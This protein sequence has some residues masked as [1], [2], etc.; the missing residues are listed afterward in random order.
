MLQDDGLPRLVD[1]AP[2]ARDPDAGQLEVLQR[3]EQP[4]LAVVEGVVVGCVLVA[5]IVSCKGE[6]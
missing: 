3:V 1:V 2:G 5:T 4:R 6:K